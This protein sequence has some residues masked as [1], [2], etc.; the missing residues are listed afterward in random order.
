MSYTQSDY[1]FASAGELFR[2]PTIEIAQLARGSAQKMGWRSAAEDTQRTE[3][4]LIDVQN[5]FR[6]Y[7]ELDD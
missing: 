7:K 1:P 2:V 3:L 4:V 5:T 6:L